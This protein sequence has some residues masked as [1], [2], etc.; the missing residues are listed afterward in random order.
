MASK[1]LTKKHEKEKEAAISPFIVFQTPVSEI[2][3]AVLANLGD[4]GVSAQDFE[5]VKIP[6]GG[7]TAWAL[8]SLDGEELVKE[9]AGII[10][11]WRDT[12]AYWSVPMEQSEGNMP[13]DCYSLDA[14]TGNGKPGG[15]CHKCAFAQF[16][17]DPKGKARRASWCGSCS[18]CEKRTCCPRLSA[19]RQVR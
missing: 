7:G 10:V 9:L 12:R 11:A 18:S 3:D 4:N 16:G 1:E 8:Q 5:R 2:R 13:P 14:R 17:S 19:C 6:A 15:D